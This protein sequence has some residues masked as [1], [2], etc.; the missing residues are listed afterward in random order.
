MLGV[1]VTASD[2]YLLLFF[3]FLFFAI[4]RHQKRLE[5]FH[6]FSSKFL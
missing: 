2:S 4:G 5:G 6:F 3:L 1:R